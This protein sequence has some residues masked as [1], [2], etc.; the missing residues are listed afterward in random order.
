MHSGRHRAS[1]WSVVPIE[2]NRAQQ[3]QGDGVWNCF[4]TDDENAK[5]WVSE[6]REVF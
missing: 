4:G 3:P 5:D 1:F 6:Q 2:N